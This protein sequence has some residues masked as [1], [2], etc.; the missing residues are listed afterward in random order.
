M[1]SEMNNL[2]CVAEGIVCKSNEY[3]DEIVH[4]YRGDNSGTLVCADFTYSDGGGHTA[5]YRLVGEHVFLLDAS[6]YLRHQLFECG[7]AVC[8]SESTLACVVARWLRSN[9]WPVEVKNG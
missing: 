7:N 8:A 6:G 1:S 3:C 4:V 2:Q 5:R 9:G